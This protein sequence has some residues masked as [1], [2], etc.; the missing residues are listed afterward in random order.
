MAKQPGA[1]SDKETAIRRILDAAY[2]EFGQRGREQAT[3]DAVAERAGLSKQLIYYYFRNKQGLYH[4][5]LADLLQR[6][7]QHYFE[8]DFDA[9]RPLD[10]IKHLFDVAYVLNQGNYSQFAVDQMHDTTVL[11]E[12]RGAVRELGRRTTEVVAR[13]VERG[14]REGSIRQDV[15]PQIVHAMLWVL[16]VGFLS[17]IRLLEEYIPADL[18]TPARKEQWRMLALDS[19]L[20]TLAAPGADKA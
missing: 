18:D 7:H 2:V 13:I 1:E 5:V 6:S 3:M 9:L 17:S 11:R 4:E 16:N 15:D 8:T 14:Q 20:S 12:M 10:A 19:I